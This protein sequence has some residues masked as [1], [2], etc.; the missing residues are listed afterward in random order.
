MALTALA[1]TSVLGFHALA[2]DVPSAPAPLPQLKVAQA[3]APAAA[4]PAAAAPASHTALLNKYCA[5]CHSGPTPRGDV[6]L[7]FKDD[8]EA[9]ATAGNDELWTKVATELTTKHMPPANV[10]NRPSD[11]ERMLLVDFVNSRVLASIKP[12]PGPF[13]V[14]RLNN[15][16]YANTLRDLLYLP[17]SYNAAADFPADERGESFDTNADTLTLSPLLI[18]RYLDAA[19]KVSREAMKPRTDIPAVQAAQVSV[20]GSTSRLND[21]S[22]DFKV[23]YA[24][25]M[26]KVKINL[27][28]FAP[29]VFRR[30]ATEQDIEGLMKFVNMAFTHDG[31]SDESI[32]RAMALA[33]RAALM[34]P[35]FLFRMESNPAADGKGA[36]FALNDW[37]LASRL[38]YFLWSS[39]PD[40]ALFAQA[41]AGTLKQNLEAQVTRMLK[42]PK[43]ISLTRDFLGQWLEIRGLES[44]PN[45]DKALLASMRA[46]TENYFNYIVT[47]NRPITDLL[48]SDYTFVDARLAKLYGIPNV[49]GDEFRKVAVDTRQRGGIMTQASILTL[50]SKPLG[51][52]LRTSPVVRG[53]FILENLFNQK[54]P[55]PPPTVP[56]LALDTNTQLK[57][58]V[59]QIFEQHRSFPS[60]AGCHARMD[61]YGFALE[62]YSG[63]GQWRLTDNGDPVDASGEIDGKAF[64][65]PV[66]FRKILASRQDDFR[67]AF[68]RKML[69]YALGRGIQGFD[70]PAVEAICAA[71]KADGDTFTS[72]ILNV[73]KS[74]PFQNAR[75]SLATAAGEKGGEARLIPASTR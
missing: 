52:G 5:G 31:L 48:Y 49:T 27:Q 61:P 3:A 23:D 34:T 9:I 4:T 50:T 37:Q 38:S 47:N 6:A 1:V 35:E 11:A 42:D 55:P 25:P 75:G 36:I 2:A 51:E 8:A 10:A 30:P 16:E 41:K 46:E 62:N 74:Y 28:A 19:E 56:A 26:E 68:V 17:A 29:R 15:R 70:R 59:R 7:R 63:T 44:T 66:E 73:V 43:G 40:D 65:G 20:A 13:L 39:M 71:V 32:D 53:K 33:I 24:N 58:T 72:V 12:D 69:S 21:P 67:R 64:A 54:L 45:V 60:C 57:G 18:E 14:R 22:K